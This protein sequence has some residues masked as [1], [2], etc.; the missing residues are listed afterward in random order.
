MGK[1]K[2]ESTR[3]RLRRVWMGIDPALNQMKISS[4]TLIL[5]M[6]GFTSTM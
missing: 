3:S 6:S 5:M 2:Y 1:D 4:N